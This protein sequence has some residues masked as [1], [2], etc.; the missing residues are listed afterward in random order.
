LL[1]KEIKP[2]FGNWASYFLKRYVWRHIFPITKDSCQL[3]ITQSAHGTRLDVTSC[4]T[5]EDG[6]YVLERRRFLVRLE[7]V[8]KDANV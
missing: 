3:N 7:E 1:V 2:T 8:D 4:I 6:S 5:N